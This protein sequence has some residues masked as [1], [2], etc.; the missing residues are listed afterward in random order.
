MSKGKIGVQMMMLKEKVEEIGIY[1]TMQKIAELGYSCVEV[2]QIPMTEE[3][4]AELKRSLADFDL[5]VAA[6]S[7]NLEPMMPGMEGETLKDDFDKI[8]ADCK[9][10]N[11]NFL[12]MG[13]LPLS[14]MGSK[15]KALEFVE[16]AD[17][18]AEKLAEHDIK[19]YYH[20]HHVEFQ[21]FEGEYLLDIIKDNTSHIGFELDVHWI[22]RGGEDP[23]DFIK[24]YDG[25]VTLL[26]L[27]DYRIGELDKS[28]L[29]TGDMEQFM[30]DFKAVVQFA[31][32][33]EGNLDMKAIIEAGLESGSKYFLIEQDDQYGR[34]PF[35]CLETSRDNLK[36]LGYGGWFKN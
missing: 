33:G 2:S 16:K 7:A 3:N 17:A 29:E 21:K 9:K 5:E 14:L 11:C 15:E 6:L 36:E 13:M 23:V 30:Q 24:K 32:V 28:S 20:N 34:D 27:K 4:V 26:H 19:L 31:E 8:V 35:A 18:V 22:Q 12:R 10:L 1:K 25:R